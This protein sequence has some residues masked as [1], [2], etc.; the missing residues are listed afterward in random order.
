MPRQAAKRVG[1]GA[2][3]SVLLTKLRPSKEVDAVFPNKAQGQRL[4]DLVAVRVAQRARRGHTFESIF[5]R[6]ETI[7]GVDLNCATRFCVVVEE[8][9]PDRLYSTHAPQGQQAQA[10][11]NTTEQETPGDPIDVAVFAPTGNHAED[12][13]TARTQGLTVDDDNEPAPENIPEANAP[14]PNVNALN[15]GQSWGWDGIDR[16]RTGG[17]VDSN[18]TFHDR[19][20]PK[21]KTF[22]EV[23]LKCIPFRFFIDKIMKGTLDTLVKKNA[24]PLEQGEFLRY[25]G[26]WLLM[27]TCMGWTRR[28]FWSLRPF[29]QE[30]AACPYR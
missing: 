15:E 13:A 20:T 8:G 9:P 30:S 24:A 7:P 25:I 18:P 5:F 26:L 4:D 21:G 29:N 3:C 12:I 10:P 2:R 27:S 23:F 6:S 28:D 14:A 11:V 19:W 1:E 17:G 16:R 22:L